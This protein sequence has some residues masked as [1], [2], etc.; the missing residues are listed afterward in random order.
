M[1]SHDFKMLVKVFVIRIIRDLID[2]VKS[3]RRGGPGTRGVAQYRG[4][5][6]R[7][8]GRQ[9]RWSLR[10]KP[11]TTSAGHVLDVGQRREGICCW[12]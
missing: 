6:Y 7:S 10:D 3:R 8:V 11:S 1:Q 2:D 9:R 12:E 4:H 5:N